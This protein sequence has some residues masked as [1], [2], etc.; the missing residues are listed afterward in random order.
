MK[1]RKVTNMADINT[2]ISTISLNVNGLTAPTDRQRINAPTERP[3][4]GV[5]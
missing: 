1:N 3:N 4:V 2:T 5:D